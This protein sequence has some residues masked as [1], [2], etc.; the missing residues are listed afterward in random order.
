MKKRKKG[1]IGK[2][3]NIIGVGQGYKRTEKSIKKNRHKEIG[4]FGHDIIV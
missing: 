4:V 1:A 2:L 3:L